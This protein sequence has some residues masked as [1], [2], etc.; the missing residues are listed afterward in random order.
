MAETN[1][2]LPITN[3]QLP[4]TNYQ[5]PIT[6]YLLPITYYLLPIY[7]NLSNYPVGLLGILLADTPRNLMMVLPPHDC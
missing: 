5:L 6:N 1:Y 2:Q 7:R 3:Y 4:I